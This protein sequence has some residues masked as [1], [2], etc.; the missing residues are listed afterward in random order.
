MTKIL[1]AVCLFSSLVYAMLIHWLKHESNNHQLIP[2]PNYQKKKNKKKSLKRNQPKWH[3]KNHENLH[4][5]SLKKQT[6]SSSFCCCLN[7]LSSLSW[8][9]DRWLASFGV[10]AAL[11]CCAC[12]RAMIYCYGSDKDSQEEVRPHQR[13][14]CKMTH[15]AIENDTDFFFSAM[16]F[17][18]WTQKTHIR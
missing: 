9:V 7:S 16:Q 4:I 8:N 10:C 6:F 12:A 3:R 5:S 2:H 15:N 18:A 13:N 14:H 1:A 17:V 11:S